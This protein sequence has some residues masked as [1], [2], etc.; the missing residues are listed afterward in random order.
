MKNLILSVFAAFAAVA[1]ATAQAT[2]GGLTIFFGDEFMAQSW[3]TPNDLPVGL[4][5]IQFP[6]SYGLIGS[7]QYTSCFQQQ[8]G[9][10]G[11]PNSCD[12]WGGGVP[13]LN[14]V[15]TTVHSINPTPFPGLPYNQ[16]KGI[17][18]G[19][20]ASAGRLS[21]RPE[22]VINL[23]HPAGDV[24]LVP[25]SDV[26]NM[27]LWSH[28]ALVG[29]SD[30]LKM[31]LGMREML[32][33][34]RAAGTFGLQNKVDYN[35]NVFHLLAAGNYG[36]D[37]VVPAIR[38][39]QIAQ[40]TSAAAAM[41]YRLRVWVMDWCAS[42]IIPNGVPNAIFLDEDM[43]FMPIRKPTWD[44]AAWVATQPLPLDPYASAVSTNWIYTDALN[45]WDAVY[46]PLDDF[47]GALKV[48]DV[49]NDSG[50]ADGAWDGSLVN[51]LHSPSPMLSN[52]GAFL[53]G[54]EVAARLH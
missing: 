46:A 7:R 41:N 10:P 9:Q 26:N 53:I 15:G 14:L 28:L 27:S 22:N 5:N 54:K 51:E 38:Q 1:P 23:C 37:P 52:Y 17:M 48:I 42:S 40:A 33:D 13:F 47:T 29:A 25:S 50:A 34:M 45:N 18:G 8:L 44:V 2:T 4:Q 35:G 16:T 43:V 30:F 3:D 19:Y 11:T 6:V 20:G 32:Y 24:G 21:Q 12:F 31:R 36:V 49:L 39:A